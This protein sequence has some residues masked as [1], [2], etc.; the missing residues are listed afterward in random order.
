MHR[1]LLPMALLNACGG[2][3]IEGRTRLQKLVFLMEQELD[4]EIGRLIQSPDYN[5][6]PYDYGPFSKQLYNDLDSLEEA[7][8]IK[9]DEEDMV[10]GKV[11]YT[12]HLTDRGESWVRDQFDSNTGI[13]EIGLLADRLK[14]KYNDVLLS[15]LIEEV[16]SEYPE[17]AENSVW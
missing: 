11:K 9:V 4:D 13:Q 15:E 8:L 16:Y 5:F 6:V 3:N 14:S 12:Y 1:K 17:Y 7:G 10:D 2:D